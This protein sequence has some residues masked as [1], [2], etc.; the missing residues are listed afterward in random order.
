MS[1]IVLIYSIFY[2]DTL[3]VV[4]DKL[5]SKDDLKFDLSLQEVIQRG[6]QLSRNFLS[7]IRNALDVADAIPDHI[8]SRS[9]TDFTFPNFPIF[10][11]S[12]LR[13]IT[14]DGGFVHIHQLFFYAMLTKRLNIEPLQHG[15]GSKKKLL[16][17]IL[18]HF[19]SSLNK[20][21]N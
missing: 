5:P 17:L 7:E 10:C 11:F 20:N 4:N 2:T 12:E 16:K 14:Y 1:G 21:F 15:N 18:S 19:L 9:N 6:K 3:L 13:T 8:V